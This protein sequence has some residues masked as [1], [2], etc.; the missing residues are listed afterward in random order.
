MSWLDT[1]NTPTLE[2]FLDLAAE[3]QTLIA[4]NIANVDTPGYR[5]LDVDFQ[6]ELK[7]AEMGL[8]GEPTAR[9]V[10]GLVER[11]D[12][13]NVSLDRETLALAETQL[14]F[15]TAVDLLRAEFRRLR[16]AIH[17]GAPR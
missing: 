15:R 16:T 1:P 5:T 14:R 8:G 13:N 4:S 17:E 9:E 11:P 10:D 7:R 6:S 12:G 2:R 3:R